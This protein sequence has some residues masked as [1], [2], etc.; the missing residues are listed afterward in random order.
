MFLASRTIL[1]GALATVYGVWLCYAAGVRYLLLATILFAPATVIF[2]SRAASAVNARL[3]QQ[4]SSLRWCWPRPPY[5]P[6][7]SCSLVASRSSCAN[8][9]RRPRLK[10]DRRD[11]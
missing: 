10:Q 8:R 2:T 1:I 6:S 5:S 11:R 7:T 9:L 3:A 4:S